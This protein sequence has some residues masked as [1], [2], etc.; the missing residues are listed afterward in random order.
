M[1]R[2]G[3]TVQIRWGAG[4]GGALG[5]RN[6]DE[7]SLTRCPWISSMSSRF[8]VPDRNAEEL[9]EKA[10]THHLLFPHVALVLPDLVSRNRR[11]VETTCG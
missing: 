1:G 7:F 8:D 10:S 4:G 6:A 5:T 3:D 2:L 9:A 11:T